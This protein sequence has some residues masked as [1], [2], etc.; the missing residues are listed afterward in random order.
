MNQPDV[1]QGYASEAAELIPRFEALRT[2]EVLAPVTTLL[3]G[4]PSRVLD[5]GAGTG[6]DA[7]WLAGKGHK[8]VAVEP[9]REFREAGMA[10]HPD[11]RISW[12][13]DRLPALERL[14]EEPCLYDLILV[15]AVWQHVPAKDHGQAIRTLVR[16]LS[17]EGRL[18]I[19]LRHGPGSP[20]RPCFPAD[21]E[22]IIS[23][24]E[25][26]GMRL[27]MRRSAASVQQR[28]R[29]QGVTWTWLCFEKP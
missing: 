12:V 26:A 20:I 7:A 4:P 2:P 18:V 17:P 1:L 10:L 14:P 28:N 19:S 15:V 29:E 16:K 6:R 21:P 5:I 9:V 3:P 24:A 8:V 11:D 22:R 23:Y 13:D 25:D 27:R